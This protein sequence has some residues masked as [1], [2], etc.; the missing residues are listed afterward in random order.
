M[1][2]SLHSV[3][4]AAEI[5]TPYRQVFA[6]AAARTGDATVYVTADLY[7]TALQLDTAQVYYLSAITPVWTSLSGGSGEVNTASNVGAG[8]GVFK[9]KTGVDLE[10]KSLVAGSGITLTPNTN[11]VT[12][13]ASGG[14]SFDM[15]DIVAFDHFVIGSNVSE[16][17]GALGWLTTVSGTGADMVSTG[18]VGH[19]GVLDMG[20]GTT[21]AGRVAIYLGDSTNFL[22]L[23]LGTTQGTIDLEWLVKVNANALSSSN[24]E[25]L[26]FGF[27]DTFDAASGAEL[28]NG[29]YA[30][31]NPTLSANWRLVTANGG[32]R[33]RTTSS[34]SNPTSGTWYR[35]T[36]RMSYPGGTPT[37]ELFVNGTSV[38]SH[39]TNIP[40]LGLGLGCR[41]DCNGT[42][43]PRVQVDYMRCTQVTNKET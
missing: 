15:R 37:A 30:E 19:P 21:A 25:R 27:G 7:K 23:A 34:G 28:T 13:A 26:C 40:T 41:L 31:F 43:E 2:T 38:A 11:D 22:N 32:T 24:T 12:I 9:Q 36:I 3:L 42:T 10:F 20:A 39:T 18:E 4:A 6:N 5:H 1:S 14:G 35:V 17:L 8:S 16:R 33:T 29:I